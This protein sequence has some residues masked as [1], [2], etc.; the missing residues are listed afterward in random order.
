M[1][2]VSDIG[3]VALVLLELLLVS[4]LG[5]YLILRFFAWLES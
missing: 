5:W 1:H 2:S 3:L 4:V